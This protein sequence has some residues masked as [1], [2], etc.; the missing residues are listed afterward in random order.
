MRDF[1]DEAE[2]KSAYY[3]E[4]EELVKRE[5]GASKVVVFDHTVRTGDKRRRARLPRS[6]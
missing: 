1:H 4:V 3:R 5:T 6:R 2:L